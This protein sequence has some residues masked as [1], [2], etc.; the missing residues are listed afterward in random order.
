MKRLHTI[1]SSI[2]FLTVFAVVFPFFLILLLK[3]PWKKGSFIV[4]NVWAFFFFNFSAIPYKIKYEF[5]PDRKKQYVFCANH[6]SIL[7]IPAMGLVVHQ[8]FAFVGKSSFAKKPFF[9]FM[10]SRFHILVNRESLKDRYNSLIKSLKAIDEGYSLV[11]F[12]EGGIKSKTPPV[13]APFKDG[14]FRAAIEKQ[15]SIVPITIGDNW[16]ALP[17]DGEVL[18]RR[19]QN[20]IIVH[21]PIDTVGLTLDN[22]D[23]LRDQCFNTIQGTLKGMHGNKTINT[24]RSKPTTKVLEKV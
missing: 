1:Y 21:K 13:L 7:D 18:L 8:P 5:K 11:I 6:F 22:I 2:I 20:R 15:I 9:G 14:A 19:I 24:A 17:D 4:N 16:R 12:P 23:S 3:K 10:Y